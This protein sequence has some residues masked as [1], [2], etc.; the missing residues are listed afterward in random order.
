ML[1][2]L[3]KGKKDLHN[4]GGQMLINLRATKIFQL[5]CVFA[6]CTGVYSVMYAT[7][8]VDILKCVSIA[9]LVMVYAIQT[10]AF[11][12]DEYMDLVYKGQMIEENE[13]LDK[14]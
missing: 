10:I 11:N 5:I 4:I 12:V 3:V 8:T 6:L 7:S 9:F 14:E 1:R 2:S 13:V